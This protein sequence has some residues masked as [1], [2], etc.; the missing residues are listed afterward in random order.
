MNLSWC[1]DHSRTDWEALSQLYK[2][3]PLGDKPAAGLEVVFSNSRYKCFIFDDSVLIGAGRALADGM[4]CSYICD[5]AVHPKYQGIGLG[6]QIVQHLID[7]SRGH[8]K[9][10]LYANPGKEGFYS[11][12]GFKKMNTAMAI[13]ENEE[14]K[15]KNG[16]LS[17]I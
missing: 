4:D 11:K 17:E 6:R 9:I 7:Q 13:F 16:T 2:I 1:F 14:E 5:I 12:L 10:I 3:A 8:K 15:I